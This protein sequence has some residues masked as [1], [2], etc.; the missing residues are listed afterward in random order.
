MK[1]VYERVLIPKKTLDL[2]SVQLSHVSQP[3]QLHGLKIRKQPN[4]CIN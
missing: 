2:V 4:F 1:K 3:N